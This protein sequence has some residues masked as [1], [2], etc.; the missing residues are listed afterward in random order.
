[1]ICLNAAWAERFYF[2][3][4]ICLG[5]MTLKQFVWI[6]VWFVDMVKSSRLCLEDIYMWNPTTKHN[7][8]VLRIPILCLNL[9]LKPFEHICFFWC[10]EPLENISHQM[11][12]TH[13]VAQ[14]STFFFREARVFCLPVT[15]WLLQRHGD[16]YIHLFIYL[17]P[18]KHSP[19]LYIYMSFQINTCNL[20]AL[21]W[22]IKPSTL[23]ILSKCTHGRVSKPIVSWNLLRNLC[24]AKGRVCLVCW[25]LTTWTK[26]PTNEADCVQLVPNCIQSKIYTVKDKP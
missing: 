12:W 9:S 20:T 22:W 26:N 13:I 14:T 2:T 17:Y 11:Q 16:I 6:L 18:C 10:Q 23:L 8:C 15:I 1:M 3:C 24:L 25:F 5:S 19:Y 4:G 7:S 21:M